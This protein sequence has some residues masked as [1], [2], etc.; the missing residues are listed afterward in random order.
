MLGEVLVLV[1]VRALF[2]VVTVVVF[3]VVTL[4][5]ALGPED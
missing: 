1:P 2:E 3:A 4:A 5:L